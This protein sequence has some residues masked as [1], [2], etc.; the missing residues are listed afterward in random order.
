M[1]RRTLLEGMKAT[2]VLI[3][4]AVLAATAISSAAQSVDQLIMVVEQNH[5]PVRNAKVFGQDAAGEV[6]LGVTDAR[7][8]L[9]V[10]VSSGETLI[11]RHGDEISAPEKSSGKAVTLVLGLKVIAQTT[12]HA[13]WYSPEINGSTGGIIALRNVT[14]GL[15]L[16]PNYRSAA[17]GGSGRQMLN[18]VPLDLPVGNAAANSATTGG[19]PAD[20]VDAVD[21]V[22]ADDGSVTPNYHVLSPTRDPRMSFAVDAQNWRGSLWKATASGI[23]GHLGYAVQLVDGGDDGRLASRT[24]LDASG[25]TY[26]HSTH[27]RHDDA[28]AVLNY[29]IGS[30]ELQVVGIGSRSHGSDVSYMMPGALPQGWGA[31]NYTLSN[32]GTAYALATMTRGRD[33]FRALHVLFDGGLHDNESSAMLAMVP[34]ASSVGFTYDGSYSEVRFARGLAHANVSM[35]AALT[36]VGVTSYVDTTN[37]TGKS[38]DST[39]ELAYDAWT[40]TQTRYGTTVRVVSNHGAFPGAAM[41]YGGYVSRYLLGNDVRVSAFDT[42]VQN[43][44]VSYASALQL[45]PATAA[46]YSCGSSSA[47]VMAPSHV[48]GVYPHAETIEAQVERSAGP[49]QIVAGGFIS[50]TRDALVSTLAQD[51]GDLDRGYVSALQQ[52]FARLCSGMS[53]AASGIFGERFESV[54]TLMSREWYI[55]PKIH[56]RDFVVQAMYET[57]SSYVPSLPADLLGIKSALIRGAQIDGIP[58]HRANLV[59]GYD[60]NHRFRSAVAVQYVSNNNSNHLPSYAETSVGAEARLGD[61]TLHFSIQNLF[62]VYN[63]AFDSPAFAQPTATSTSFLYLPA[64]PVPR[65]WSLGYTVQLGPGSR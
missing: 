15:S 38:T 30:L 18:G 48:D 9:R 40:N 20:L 17:E 23:R 53:L 7:G 46:Q 27:A 39:L 55:E 47:I 21:P 54:P 33:T 4:G 41:E 29:G 16:L 31:G 1:R 3:A 64:T 12:A 45:A 8:R 63:Y 37:Y 13:R 60:A 56:L 52:G 32:F 10:S 35:R 65:T 14:S 34:V 49:V 36:R 59:V 58:L 62:N 6:L 19:V 2:S 61:G 57:N 42:R 44:R 5:T 22:Q 25:E 28:S 26:D 43:N 50:E 51:V 11:A 24:F